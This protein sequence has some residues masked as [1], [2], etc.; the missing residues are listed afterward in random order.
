MSE[1]VEAICDLLLGAA[2]ADQS[3]HEKEKAVIR[4][5]L[6]GLT[7]ESEMEALDKRIEGFSMDS[8]D[9]ESVVAT[10]VDDSGDDKH[11][12]IKV[13]AAVH[14]ADDEHDLGEDE[15]LRKVAGSLAVDTA[16][17]REL[18]LD[19]QVETL[20]DHMEKLRTPPPIPKDA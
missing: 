9:F 18:V 3:M 8:F 4:E 14:T 10:F 6:G 17:L 11:K 7:S 15:Y 19:Y 2:Y 13:L 12:L 20:K 5:Y 16:D 1:R